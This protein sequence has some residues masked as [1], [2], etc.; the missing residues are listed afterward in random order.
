M[1]ILQWSY[2]VFVNLPIILSFGTSITLD[3][4]NHMMAKKTNNNDSNVEVNISDEE[5]R[6]RERIP[7]RVTMIN[8]SLMI[9]ALACTSIKNWFDMDLET[10]VLALVIPISLVNALRNPIVSAF[11]FRLNRQIQR[12]SVE[13]KRQKEIQDALKKRAERRK[14]KEENQSQVQPPVVFSIQT[15]KEVIKIPIVLR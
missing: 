3:I 8:S 5:K 10:R 4:L 15:S 2:L 13:D 6:Q 7:K 11:A 14:A 9:F 1:L 12:E